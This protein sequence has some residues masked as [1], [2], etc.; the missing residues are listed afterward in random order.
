MNPASSIGLLLCVVLACYFLAA[1]GPA[2][3]HDMHLAHRP[4]TCPD[5]DQP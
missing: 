4:G 5:C 1:L 2:I 3:R